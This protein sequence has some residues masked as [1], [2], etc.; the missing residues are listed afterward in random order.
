[1]LVRMER[2]Q[3]GVVTQPHQ[4]RELFW[5]QYIAQGYDSLDPR[6][7]LIES[8]ANVLT[9]SAGWQILSA[10]LNLES[11]EVA[12]GVDLAALLDR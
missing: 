7:Q 9:T 2:A 3:V 11:N 8:I 12:V 5:K 4:E 6:A 1:M 10:H